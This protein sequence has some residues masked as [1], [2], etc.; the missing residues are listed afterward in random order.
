MI[1][2]FPFSRCSPNS[3]VVD[4]SMLQETFLAFRI[5]HKHYI[6]DQSHNSSQ[7]PDMEKKFCPA[8]VLNSQ[9]ENVRE[10]KLDNFV[11]V[12]CKIH[13]CHALG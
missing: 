10:K 2:C 8:D 5:N 12:V 6:S 1:S 3:P 7:T 9:A 4:Q 13:I 11:H